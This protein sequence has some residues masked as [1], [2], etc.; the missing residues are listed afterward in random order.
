MVIMSKAIASGT[1][2]MMDN[3]QISAISIAIHFGTP[4]PLIRLHEAT[5]RYLK[6]PTCAVS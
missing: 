5:A 4:I 3:I 1:A 6:H 2:K